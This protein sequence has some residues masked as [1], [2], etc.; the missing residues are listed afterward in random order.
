M[1]TPLLF[2][3]LLA[4]SPLSAQFT[5]SD[6]FAGET[7]NAAKWGPDVSGGSGQLTQV[8]G[9][10][11]YT[12][13]GL[14]DDDFMAW[15][16]IV[17]TGALDQNWSIQ[18]DVHVPII[19]LPE[20]YAAAGIGIGVRN[21]DNPDDN[22]TVALENERSPGQAQRFDYLN[23]VDVDGE[24]DD[25]T[26]P[27]TGPNGAVRIS[28]NA[29]TRTLTAEFDAD[30]A[31]NGY[32]W[33]PFNS[34]NPESGG[35]LMGPEASLEIFLLGASENVAVTEDH[36][37]HAD[38]FAVALAEPANLFG[39]DN[40]NDD[41]RDSTKW[42]LDE[43]ENTGML[44]EIDGRLEY[45]GQAPE[46]AFGGYAER[47]WILNTGSYT[48]NWEARVDVHVGNL[49]LPDEE[50]GVQMALAVY[51]NGSIGEIKLEIA[52]ENEN[53]LRRFR[54][55]TDG[56]VGETTAATATTDGALRISFNAAQ[57]VLTFAYDAN[58]PVGGYTWTTLKTVDVDAGASNWA[59][60]D[61]SRFTLAIFGEHEG[62]MVEPGDAWADNFE[63]TSALP[64]VVVG[65]P[66]GGD[67]F[68]GSTKDTGKWGNDIKEGSGQFT[69]SGGVLR[70]TASS[71]SGDSS[72]IR[73]WLVAA[74]FATDWSVQLDV[75]VPW[76]PLA[77]DFSAVGI[78][79]F[80]FHSIDSEDQFSSTLENYRYPGAPQ[81]FHFFNEVESDGEGEETFV[82]APSSHAAVRISWNAASQTLSAAYDADGRLNGY[83]WTVYKNFNPV[84]QGWNMTPA[85][86]FRIAIDGSS[87]ITQVTAAHDVHA[88][89][90]RTFGMPGNP[91]APV[92]KTLAA[93]GIVFDGATL[94]GSVDAKGAER[95]V[96]FDYGTTTGFGMSV[97]A[98]PASVD[99]TG[100]Q[101]VSAAIEGLLPHTKYF[102][103]TRAEGTQG[104][105][106]AA[107]LSF[108]T[109]N[110]APTGNDD[111][112][113][114]L[115]GS[116]VALD[117]LAN[118][119][120]PDG[121]PLSLTS[122][123]APAAGAK[124]KKTGNTLLLTTAASFSA[125]NAFSYKLAD[126]FGGSGQANVTL[127]PGTL[128]LDLAANDDLTSAGGSYD[129]EVTANGLWSMTAPA[130][131]RAEPAAGNGDTTVTLSVLP[132]TSAKP[133]TAT[134]LIGGVAHTVTQAGVLK[135]AL[136]MPAE[137]PDGIVS[138]NY[139][140]LIPVENLPVVFSIKNLPPGL[141][142]NGATGSITGKPLKGGTYPVEIRAKNAAD[143]ADE[144]LTFDIEIAALD[145]GLVGLFHGLVD[146]HPDHNGQLG[147][148][149]ELT[150][151]S[152]GAVSGKAITGTVANP[153]KGRL[154]ANVDDPKH[155]ACTLS[156]PRKGLPPL[157]V[158][159]WFEADDSA[160][161]G[162][163]YEDDPE[164]DA[165]V[166]AWRNP[167]KKLGPT[168]SDA[169]FAGPHSFRLI[170]NDA[171]PG[172][173]QGDGFGSFTVS[174]A[175]GSLS[176]A[177]KTGDGAAFVG[178]TFIGQEGQVL[179]YQSLYA[180]RGS[181]AG[182]LQVNAGATPA[183]NT[184]G[185]SALWFKPDGGET[186]K[187]TLY[188]RGFELPLDVDGGGYPLIEKGDLVMGLE[189]GNNNALIEF[190]AGGLD[191]DGFDQLFTVLNPSA[192]GVTNKAVVV[193]D[194]GT[195]P[196]RV[197][198]TKFDA[199]TGALAGEFWIGT[200]K[201]PWFGQL[202]QTGGE[203]RGHGF[204]L[205]PETTGSGAQ[206]LSGLLFL[207]PTE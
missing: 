175:N 133:R 80:V 65:T 127:T 109:A 164:E 207:S 94:N 200:R 201:A 61:A 39:A 181:L 30:G 169:G 153:F 21:S 56:D 142:A 205:L 139:E 113:T 177:G 135:P 123:T 103:R 62:V 146:P 187:D 70:Y 112:F 18:A 31:A 160:L 84:T 97:P 166:E 170:Q 8:G 54:Y 193:K 195:N 81:S 87:E 25:F 28:W 50:S 151:A 189:P 173:P 58:G 71:A 24:G 120:D 140:L 95:D 99:G 98:V 12:S 158:E 78:G 14:T 136:A 59:M 52:R 190:S 44:M 48:E 83:S 6:D 194:D 33:T 204:F 125:P 126:G 128:E 89:N 16:W 206:R 22:F 57:K 150:V 41:K 154:D 13:T 114:V 183:D 85:G 67:D 182:V 20:G 197:K 191:G 134:V 180:K 161:A 186:S 88:D 202:V 167:W 156:L 155:P 168:P 105:A 15:P 11:R 102:F 159:V 176:L 4:A 91:V 3:L 17:G 23:G 9:V 174:T 69:Q 82:D 116:V 199:K 171:D 147:S 111:S 45:T 47:P 117:V 2:F 46:D 203:V 79:L 101:A 157:Q 68:T 188:P 93:T 144:V 96:F 75:H 100:V 122:V 5:G 10:V 132:N 172:L 148:R 118:D 110:R 104:A 77:D 196:N 106:S 26:H 130:W 43:S 34:F 184:V 29:A 55:T 60:T 42:G 74:P 38:N 107:P 198:V 36:A 53:T 49:T 141:S 137:I 129:V 185:G 32:Q 121:D 1:K 90:F 131:V 92:V 115:P 35:W 64:S 165:A 76:I 138:G 143:S 72:M 37:V 7:K 40:F 149:L 86:R 145:E 63:T 162:S 27:A 66:T 73:P 119:A 163:V 179:L 19:A 152:T 108:T 124:V 51:G 192:T 178:K